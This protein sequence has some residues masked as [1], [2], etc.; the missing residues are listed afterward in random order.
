MLVGRWSALR[1][2]QQAPVVLSASNCFVR[3]VQWKS[4]TRKMENDYS[5]WTAEKLVERVT[6]LEEQLR[7]LTSKYIYCIASYCLDLTC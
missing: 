3:Y 1:R 2:V 5:S 4:D 6:S 7:D